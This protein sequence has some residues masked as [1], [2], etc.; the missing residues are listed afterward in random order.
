VT[1]AAIAQMTERELLDSVLEL[2]HLFG[3]LRAHFRPAMTKHGW[4]TPVAADGKGFSDLLMCRERLVIAELKSERGQTTPEQ[5]D[6]LA[7]LSNAG[8]ETHVWRP[9]NW[10]SGEIEAAL[11]RRSSPEP[12]S[13]HQPPTMKGAA[14]CGAA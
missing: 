9:S 10:Q 12:I 6:W 11:R 8:I 3:W 4:R 2:A 13:K 7:A 5:L 14:Q 1:T